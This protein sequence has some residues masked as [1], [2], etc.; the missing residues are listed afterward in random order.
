MADEV[1]LCCRLERGGQEAAGAGTGR[2]EPG[3]KGSAQW[4]PKTMWAIGE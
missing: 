3:R 4:D 2:T 1:E